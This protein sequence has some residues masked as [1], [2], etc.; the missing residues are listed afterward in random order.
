MSE[1]G[2]DLHSLFPGQGPALHALKLQDAHFRTLAEQH[3]DVTLE[4]QRIEDGLVAA[5]D[6]RVEALKKQ[7]LQLLDEVAALVAAHEAA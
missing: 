6:Q 5:S 7:R 3:H 4:I 1:T 2:H